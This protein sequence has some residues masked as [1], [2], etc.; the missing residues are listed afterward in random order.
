[1]LTL[2][3]SLI[4]ALPQAETDKLKEAWP[5][6]VEAWRA[7]DTY[8]AEKEEL[9]DDFLKLMGRL[10]DAFSAAGMLDGA[11]FEAGALKRLF[12]LRAAR[13]LPRTSYDEVVVARAWAAQRFAEGQP[14]KAGL[15]GLLAGLSR[16]KELRDKGLDDEDNVADETAA[17]RKS[18]KELKIVADDTPQWLRRRALELTRAVV[19]GGAWP[20]R[21]KAT[22]EQ[23]AQAKR[24]ID[25]LDDND[26]E[27]REKAMRELMKIGDAVLPVL[28]AALKGASGEAAE[29]IKRVL[30]EGHEPWRMA[31][32][33]RPADP[34]LRERAA[35]I[36][37]LKALER[38]KD[39]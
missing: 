28:R 26:P 35:V 2:A 27:V 1:M 9:S 21:P 12:K 5:K 32:E 3:A 6:V 20:E 11:D 25:E 24:W 15:D 7:M 8:K 39:K 18:M 33:E 10:H 17:V 19:A 34:V 31:R 30:G 4:A 37:A 13:L 22:A 23:E 14:A 38:P 16:L 29:R 36:E